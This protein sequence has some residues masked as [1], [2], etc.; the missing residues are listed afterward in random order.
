MSKEEQLGWERQYGR[1]AA[2]AAILAV[3]VQLAAQV[4]QNSALADSGNGQRGLLTKLD[5]VGGQVVAGRVIQAVSVVFVVAAL[6]YLLRCTRN[7]RDVMPGIVGLLVLSPILIGVGGVLTQL[8]LNDVASDFVSTGER[9]EKRADDLI[10]DREAA[11]LFIGLAGTIALGFSYIVISLGAMRAGLLSRFMG[12]LG[13]IVGVFLVVPLFPPAPLIQVFW[14]GALGILFLGRWPGGRGPA[15]ESGEEEQW[16]RMADQRA[17]MLR[18][19]Q[20]QK[21]EESAAAGNEDEPRPQSR[22]RRKK[23]R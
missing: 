10:A 5:E 18:Q 4:V 6:L 19:Q 7:R 12:V 3:V 2:V 15:W 13:I 8:D 21:A 22:K 11:P 23:R 1:L 9:T 20:A 14:L 16:P 17:E